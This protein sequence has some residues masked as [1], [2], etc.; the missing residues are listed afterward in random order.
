MAKFIESLDSQINKLIREISQSKDLTTNTLLKSKVSLQLTKIH[1]GLKIVE[2]LNRL[3]HIQGEIEDRLL[4]EDSIKDL[5]IRELLVMSSVNSKRIDNYFGK[6]DKILAGLNI[7]ELENSLLMISEMDSKN[8]NPSAGITDE[9]KNLTNL[10]MQLLK[11]ITNLQDKSIEDQNS[12]ELTSTQL[13]SD[14]NNRVINSTR[15]EFILNDEDNDELHAESLVSRLEKV[16]GHDEDEDD[17]EILRD[18]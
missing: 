11:T 9:S 17:I 4:S 5:S 14:L 7:R 12:D 13:S 3:F 2:R 1:F 18:L 6:M 15:E 10:S 16:A 8:A